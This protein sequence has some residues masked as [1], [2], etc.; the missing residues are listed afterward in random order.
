MHQLKSWR[1][2]VKY[3]DKLRAKMGRSTGIDEVIV[4]SVEG[5][6]TG[7]CDRQGDN[8][9]EDGTTSAKQPFAL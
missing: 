1:A 2:R 9:G 5:E 3:L 8:T 6:M 4:T 7:D